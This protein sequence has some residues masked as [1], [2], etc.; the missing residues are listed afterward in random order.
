MN[1]LEKQ[2]PLFPKGE[3]A[4]DEYFTGNTWVNN[5]VP[6]EGPFNTW[7]GNVVFEPGARNNWH[8]HPGG[9]VLIATAG[10]GYYQ[11]KGKP[12]QL[13]HPG[14]VVQ[15]PP[16]VVHWHGASPDSEFTHIAITTNTQ[17]GIVVWLERVTDQEYHSLANAVTNTK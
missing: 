15:I 2:K 12:I 13:L 14:D 8:T 10:V 1:T 5:L 17:K 4:S 3:K 7:I 11:E 16:G 6:A 9:Q